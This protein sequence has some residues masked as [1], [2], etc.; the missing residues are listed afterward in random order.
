MGTDPAGA[1]ST[2]G[3]A[4]GRRPGSRECGQ[5][6]TR[7]RNCPVAS[8]IRTRCRVGATGG[9][10]TGRLRP[11][12]GRLGLRVWLRSGFGALTG[13]RA[14]WGFKGLF[15]TIGRIGLLS[16]LDGWI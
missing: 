15:A 13:V 10:G 4:E 12:R 2:A 9:F 8:R 11:R 3:V 1:L 16:F 6:G 5:S 14:V 7:S